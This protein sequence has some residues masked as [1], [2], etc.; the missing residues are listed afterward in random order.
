MLSLLIFGVLSG[1]SEFISLIFNMVKEDISNTRAAD[2]YQSDMEYLQDEL[3]RLDLLLQLQMLKSRSKGSA[4]DPFKG[5]YISDDEADALLKGSESQAMQT[6]HDPAVTVQEDLFLEAERGI[7]A[8]IERTLEA[9]VELRLWRL[10][11]T[12]GLSKHESDA[13]VVCLA[14]ELDPKYERLFGYIQDDLTRKR[15]TPGL[16]LAI[17]FP[18]FEDKLK[19][20]SI[21]LPQS[22]LFKDGILELADERDEELHLSS[23]LRINAEVLNYLLGKDEQIGVDEGQIEEL[24][25]ESDDCSSVLKTI[26][27]EDLFCKVQNLLDCL[28]DKKQ[29]R[30]IISLQGPYGIGKSAIVN[31]ICRALRIKPIKIDFESLL[32]SAAFEERKIDSILSQLLKSARLRGCPVWLDGFDA[33]GEDELKAL[34]IRAIMLRRLESFPGLVFISGQSPIQLEGKW[35]RDLFRLEIPQ[36]EYLAR[37]RCWERLF[38]NKP[39]QFD[40]ETVSELAAK[41]RFTTGQIEDALSAARSFAAL[42][43]R[44]IISKEDLY[45][46][47]RAQSSIKLSTLT[48]RI[49]PRYSFE[50]IVLPE[51]SLKLLLDIRNYIRYKG[52]VYHEW[53]FGEKLSLG[54]GLNILFSGSSG[55]GKTMAA[56]VLAHELDLELYKI[57]LSGIVSKYIGE[58]EKNL[59]KI[60]KEAEQS[61][62]I[63]FFDEADAIFG[64][65]SEVKD[66][67]DRYA[68]IEISYLL[69]KMEE[70]EGVAILATNFSKNMDDAFLRRMQFIVEFPF[71]E[72]DFRLRIWK[73]LLPERAPLANDIDFDFLARSFKLAGGNIKNILVAA[74]F[75]AAEN[76]G[77]I[78][79]EHLVKAAGK[80]YRK[81]GKVCSQSDFGMYYHLISE[82]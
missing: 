12:F 24:I 74:A 49:I 19:Y 1:K 26:I 40:E 21:F 70:H 38:Q 55:T 10:A 34:Q 17:L 39:D 53:G 33:M 68:N 5:L 31:Y 16:I 43:G 14:Q 50:D 76:S 11:K 82:N 20:R 25:I 29:S 60:F 27:P 13:V 54:K 77:V 32:A 51:N 64:K 23:G 15:P 22:P 2:F 44:S 59:N 36:L 66:A 28:R 81:I 42:A 52:I 72:V 37:K 56:E 63:L 62:A 9:G 45:Q 61:N 69:Q 6:L 75:L 67:H 48:R 30:R 8:K 7:N 18:S 71:P 73:G 41:F 47:C 79:M 65:R 58:T 80:E 35:Q 3:R 46:G 57:D 4:N 78:N